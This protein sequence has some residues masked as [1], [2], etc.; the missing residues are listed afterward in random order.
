MLFNIYVQ[1]DIIYIETR[2][3]ENPKPQKGFD[4][5]KK[6]EMN[7]LA[8][9]FLKYRYFD[10]D[11]LTGWEEYAVLLDVYS[12]LPNEMKDYIRDYYYLH[13]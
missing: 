6:R 10:D 3:E 7:N 2:E 1:C 9:V 5:M 11:R 13:V 12:A 8:K 4:V